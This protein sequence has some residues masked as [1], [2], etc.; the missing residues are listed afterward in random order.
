MKSKKGYLESI[1]KEYSELKKQLMESNDQ[2]EQREIRK[3]LKSIITKILQLEKK[4]MPL[5]QLNAYHRELRKIKHENNE[6]IKG[7]KVRKKT[8]KIVRQALKLEQIPSKYSI[9]VLSDER[10]KSNKPK[11][12]AVTHVARYDIEASIEA[13]K[14]NAF[15]LWGDVGE[16]YRSPEILLLKALGVV[17]VDVEIPN[18]ASEEEL[19]SIKED[20]HISLETIIKILKQNGNVLIFPEGAWNTTDNIVVTKLFTGAVEAAIRG[21]AEIVPVA[22]DK[23][24]NNRY[25][26]KVGRNI[27]TSTMRLE[28]KEEESEKLRSILAGLKYDIWEHIEKIEG[29]TRRSEMPPNARKVYL[30]GIMKDS[31]NGYTLE[32]IEKT[33][34]RDKKITTPEEAFD[35][36]GKIKLR[37]ENAFLFKGLTPLEREEQVKRLLERQENGIL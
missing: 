14:E 33:R 21:E 22:I 34:Y 13:I 30:D 25:Y 19:K 2:L 4:E 15:I 32:A 37:K 16:L 9:K 26:V 5:R 17:P 23:D 20:R 12:Y 11:V 7:I 8:Q 3:K 29:P 36:L 28:D 10:I 24:K 35:H 1:K 31:A 27:D 6:P 18:E